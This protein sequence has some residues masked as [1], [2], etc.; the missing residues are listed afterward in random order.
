MTD[1]T[2]A[3]QAGVDAFQGQLARF[4][5]VCRWSSDRDL[6][7]DTR[8]WGWAVLDVVVHVR[9]GVEE[10]LHGVITRTAAPNDIDAASYWTTTP[11]RTDSTADD[12]DAVL[13]SR[14]TS[15][16]YRRPTS[17]VAHLES[18]AG[19]LTAAT[20]AMPEHHIS[21]QGHV[22]TS[23]DFLATWAVELAIHQLDI[24]AQLDRA[25][26]TEESLRLCRATIEALVD[27]PIS[28]ALDDIT[29]ALLGSGR[30]RPDDEQ[31]LLLA[32]SASI[33]PVLG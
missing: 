13:W 14:R 20:A 6:L 29:V 22:L 19:T 5:Q 12:I 27:A 24:T 28:P 23:G 10:M 1:L 2:I 8:C 3:H 11:P 7:A 17:A 33:L 18:V 32:A 26:P 30:Q 15:S 9:S 21:F 4:V 16:A 25:Q 31:T